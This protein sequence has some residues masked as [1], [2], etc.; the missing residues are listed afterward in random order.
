MDDEIQSEPPRGMREEAITA[1]HPL[2]KM[3]DGTR[4]LYKLADKNTASFH[5]LPVILIV[6]FASCLS[7][8]LLG[9]MWGDYV[10]Y[11]YRDFYL[12]SW[13]SASRGIDGI[14]IGLWLGTLLLLRLYRRSLRQDHPFVIL[15]TSFSAGGLFGVLFSFIIDPPWNHQLRPKDLLDLAITKRWDVELMG[16][17]F[18]CA[19]IGLAM[20]V[21]LLLFLKIQTF[22]KSLQ[23]PDGRTRNDPAV[24][25]EVIPIRP[26]ESQAIQ[27]FPTKK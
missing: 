7:G 16:T 11:H 24:S 13:H 14:L 3:A 19:M 21:V 10:T 26:E 2:P 22:W 23:T 4:D 20:G 6:L 8:C 18:E 17:A 25:C 9:K 27:E 15:F 5:P 12:A 1:R